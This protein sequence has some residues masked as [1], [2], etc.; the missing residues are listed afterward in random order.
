MKTKKKK[1]CGYIFKDFGHERN[2]NGNG[3]FVNGVQRYA[4]KE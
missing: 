1:K 4:M 3:L 2:E